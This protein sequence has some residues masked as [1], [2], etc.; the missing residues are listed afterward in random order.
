MIVAAV[1]ASFAAISNFDI[2]SKMS[3]F[4]NRS[5]TYQSAFAANPQ[6]CLMSKSDVAEITSGHKVPKKVPKDY[7]VKDWFTNTGE[8]GLFYATGDMCGPNATQKSFADGVI[9]YYTANKDSSLE[10]ISTPELYFDNYKNNS[11]YPDRI[12]IKKIDGH[13]A[14]IWD[15]GMEKNLFIKENGEIFAQDEVPYPA[16]ITLVDKE[17]GRLYVAKGNVSLETL[18]DMIESAIKH[19]EVS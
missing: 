8:L 13:T 16:Q 19:K 9:M 6:D 4:E 11:D 5:N 18:E 15:K 10:M 2:N 17:D 12:T 1:L 3:I 7:G 14:M